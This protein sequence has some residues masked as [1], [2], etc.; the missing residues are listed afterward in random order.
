MRRG[1]KEGAKDLAI[2]APPQ[3]E[4]ALEQ[5]KEQLKGVEK[6]DIDVLTTSWA[7]LEKSVI[8]ILG[9]AFAPDKHEHQAVALGLAGV[10]AQKLGADTQSFWFQNREAME[11][12]SLGFS[13]ALIVLSP[14]G[15]VMDAL[16]QS[17]LAQLEN[18]AGDVRKSLAQVRFGGGQAAR[19]SPVDYERLF[20]PG[21]L[22]FVVMDAAKTKQVWETPTRKVSSDIRDAISRATQLPAEVRQQLEGQL[23]G[24]LS[25]LDQDKG[26]LAQAER[27]G[28]V[29][30]LVGHLFGTVGST[31]SAPE[32]FWHDMAFPLLYIGAPMS[33]PPVDAEEL[34]AFTKGVDPLF[35]FI[36]LVP[37]QTP[38][39]EGAL[40]DTFPPQELA[41]PH[42]EMGRVRNLHLI[43]LPKA[44]LAPLIEKF[45]P[46][47]SRESLDAFTKMLQEKSGK[48]G[49]PSDEAKAM[50]EGAMA[51]LTD[52]K[53]AMET[54]T[55]QNGELYLRRLTEAEASSDPALAVVRTALSAPRII[56]T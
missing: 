22:Q 50:L 37:Y 13:D 45:D 34:D 1:R 43:Q 16:S 12:A 47:K 46:V 32:E 49:P 48:S 24:V 28:R 53:A 41:L 2:P 56:L 4:I 17:K 44:R 39:E 42:P 40:L 21:F 6:K 25:R 30:E 14:F 55:K 35:L 54:A 11:G 38:S 5:L 26:L 36:D 52:L 19:L 29:A 7:D 51:L 8:K 10:L 15:A 9:G 20:D 3:I 31:G 23:I 27:T 33:F 18:L